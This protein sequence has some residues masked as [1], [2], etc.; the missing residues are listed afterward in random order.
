MKARVLHVV[1]VGALA[2]GIACALTLPASAKLQTVTV[3]LLDGSVV[4]R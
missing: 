1:L 2:A 4:T 3:R